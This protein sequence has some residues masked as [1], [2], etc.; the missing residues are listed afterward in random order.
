MGKHRDRKSE[1]DAIRQ[2]LRH[3]WNPIGFPVPVDEYDSYIGTIHRMIK[4]GAST[5][6]LAVQLEK[7]ETGSLGLEPNPESNEQ[8]A[9]RLLSLFQ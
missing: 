8:V 6:E 2:V 4:A 3:E 1:I 7:V 5:Q 9:R